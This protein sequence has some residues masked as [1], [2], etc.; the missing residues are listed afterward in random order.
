MTFS[1]ITW[2]DYDAIFEACGIIYIKVTFW[3]Y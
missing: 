2:R 1:S 3:G